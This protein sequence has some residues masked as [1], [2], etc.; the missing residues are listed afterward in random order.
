M[1]TIR[2]KAVIDFDFEYDDIVDDEALMR[3][4]ALEELATVLGEFFRVHGILVSSKGFEG[5][6]SLAASAESIANTLEKQT[7]QRKES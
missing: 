4:C 3:D 1:K 2:L 7:L 6:E 5:V